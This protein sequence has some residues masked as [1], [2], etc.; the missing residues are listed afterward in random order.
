MPSTEVARPVETALAELDTA[1]SALARE[2][3]PRIEEIK[4]QLDLGSSTSVLNFAT[5]PERE[6]AQFAD[7]VLDQVS[8]RDY[9]PVH[10]RLSEI[11]LIASGLDTNRLKDGGGFLS[12]LFTSAK[13]EIAK[14]SDQ[15]QSARDQIDSITNRLEDH[16]QEI[17]LGIIKLDQLFEANL[18]KFRDLTLHIVAGHEVLEHARSTLLPEA[19]AQAKAHEN[20]PDALVHAQK[21]RDLKAAIDRLDRKLMNLEKSK[22]IA[23]TSLPTIRQV[24]QTGVLLIEELKGA[25]AHA[26]PAWKS[27]MIIHIEQMRQRQGLETLGA[28]TDFTNEQLRNMATALDE[29]A[30]AIHQQTT[31]GIADVDAI[32]GAIHGLI[33]T[34]DKIDTLEREARDAREAG[35]KALAEAESELRARQTAIE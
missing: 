5:E 31:R 16:I 35:R 19:E 8:G 25:I 33:G 22:S 10:E 20:D 24:Q 27:T 28:M 17:N 32:T 29:N 34:L 1:D 18:Q 30:V 4:R 21:V 15:F 3:R 7:S 6:V 26:I 11:K 13:R 2:N 23:F 12:R 14:F 9:G